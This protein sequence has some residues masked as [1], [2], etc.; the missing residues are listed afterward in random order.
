MLPAPIPVCILKNICKPGKHAGQNG[1]PVPPARGNDRIRGW[2]GALSGTGRPGQGEP[3]ELRRFE[4]VA[5]R[6]EI[7]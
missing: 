3:V 7:G 1:G 6:S 2:S 4:I 5:G